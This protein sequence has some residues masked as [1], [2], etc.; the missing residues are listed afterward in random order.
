MPV[1]THVY[2]W[3]SPPPTLGGVVGISSDGDDR[4]EPKVKTQK[5]PLGFQQNPKKFLDQI[6]VEVL[7]TAGHYGTMQTIA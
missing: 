3:Q 5:N 1:Q 7:Y 6:L 2:S 4:M